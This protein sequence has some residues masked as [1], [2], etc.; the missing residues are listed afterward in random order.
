MP[1]KVKPVDNYPSSFFTLVEQAE[2][3]GDFFLLVEGE[4]K[5][6]S[7]M[8]IGLRTQLYCFLASIRKEAEVWEKEM[9][10]WVERDQSKIGGK[11]MPTKI[12]A[13]AH[14]EFAKGT[15][16]RIEEGGVRLYSKNKTSMAEL[17]ERNLRLG[18]KEERGQIDNGEQESLKRWQEKEEK[19]RREEEEKWINT[20]IPVVT[21]KG[22]ELLTDEDIL[23]E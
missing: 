12:W 9:K 13:A 4:G 2:V 15:A 20:P 18:F 10:A 6:H 3:K 19:E 8:K 7:N 14:R 17:V 5:E 22:K 23:K 11:P 21:F 1:R 16:I